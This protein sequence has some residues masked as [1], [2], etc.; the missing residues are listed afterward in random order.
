MPDNQFTSAGPPPAPYSF[1]FVIG[2]TY[3]ACAVWYEK[4]DPSEKAGKPLYVACGVG[5]LTRLTFPHFS[6]IQSTMAAVYAAAQERPSGDWASV[7]FLDTSVRD[8][9]NCGAAKALDAPGLEF[10]P[11]TAHFVS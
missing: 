7:E 2:D 8:P 9:L 4:S 3:G 6:I 1:P 10:A 11:D 5:V